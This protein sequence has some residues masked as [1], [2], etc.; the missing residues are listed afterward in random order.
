MAKVLKCGE[1]FPGCSIE[2]RGETEDEI[3][4]QAAAHAKRDHGVKEIDAATLAKVKGAI[5][6]A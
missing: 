6:N 1:L 5:R 2:A 4:Q 3:L